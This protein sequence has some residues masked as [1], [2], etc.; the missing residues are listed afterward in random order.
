MPLKPPFMN[1]SLFE[2]SLQQM[3]SDNRGNSVKGKQ[4]LRQAL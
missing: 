3:R 1:V 4:E 2:V